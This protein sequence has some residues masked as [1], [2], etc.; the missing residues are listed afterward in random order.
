MTVL[1]ATAAAGRRPPA[2]SS[3]ELPGGRGLASPLDPSRGHA[4]TTE[5]S[6]CQV[7][8]LQG[9]APVNGSSSLT[10]LPCS[11][12]PQLPRACWQGEAPDQSP[13]GQ[14]G[15][16]T[17]SPCEKPAPEPTRPEAGGGGTRPGLPAPALASVCHGPRDIAGAWVSLQRGTPPPARSPTPTCREPAGHWLVL[18]G[19]G[20]RRMEWTRRSGD[21]PEILSTSCRL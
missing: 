3:A 18:C 9:G 13:G 14:G 8:P 7:D 21:L 1:G 6:G 11:Q 2:S 10:A 19:P 5:A 16:M 4:S 15:W 17:P 12:R 20:L